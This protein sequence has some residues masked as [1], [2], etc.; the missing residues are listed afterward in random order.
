MCRIISVFFCFFTGMVSLFA[1]PIE[2]G[3]GAKS[4]GMGGAFVGIAN[5]ASATY[6]NPAGLLW[7]KSGEAR[8]M[9]WILSDVPGI[10]VD[11]FSLIH[12]D[13]WGISW[14]RKGATLEQGKDNVIKTSMAENTYSVSYGVR[15]LKILSIGITANRFS[16][17]SD[18]SGASGFGCNVGILY[19]PIPRYPFQAGFL[20][21]NISANIGDE[22]FPT[23]YRIGVS[24]RVIENLTLALDLSTKHGVNR[25]NRTIIHYFGGLE[26]QIVPQF[27]LR[28]GNND[29]NP[30]NVGF[31]FELGKVLLDYAYSSMKE[32][33]LTNSHRIELGYRF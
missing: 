14:L 32:G 19:I 1:A 12:P 6:W 13:G 25:A 17:N 11:W 27:A 33:G 20:I 8:F 30:I 2:I 10:G 21:R 29:N 7:T 22:N 26:W 24:G 23:T 31:G 4:Q 3:I 9:H 18:I 5:D 16:I 15:L 28:V